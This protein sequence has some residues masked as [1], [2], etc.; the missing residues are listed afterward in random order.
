MHNAEAVEL[1]IGAMESAGFLEDVD[2]ALVQGVR[3]LA[4]AVDADPSN[5]SLW[6]EYRGLLADLRELGDGDTDAF[7]ALLESLRSPVRNPS[8]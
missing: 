7:A 6:R 2:S 8:E 5:A 4:A 1:T 3:S